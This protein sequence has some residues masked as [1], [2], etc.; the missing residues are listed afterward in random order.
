MQLDKI[1][2]TQFLDAT[3]GLP[4]SSLTGV[5]I[6]ILEI[7]ELDG[8]TSSIPVN[9]QACINGGN[10]FYR[11][12]YSGMGDTLYE[13][14]INPNN[15]NTVIS[16]G[17]VDKRLNR[18]DKNVSDIV[19]TGS[20]GGGGG[21]GKI[22]SMIKDIDKNALKDLTKKAE[23]IYSKVYE[24][25]KDTKAIRESMPKSEM[26]AMK[27]LLDNSQGLIL[28]SISKIGKDDNKSDMI[29]TMKAISE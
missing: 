1:F 25:G 12:Y 11:Y 26:N 22:V 24:I 14:F 17:W 4:L 18:L 23:E 27:E 29:D 2:S 5:T 20:T 28:D 16:S 8:T 3:T 15:T 10:G 7:N 21:G 6:T 19:L 9:A 13:Y